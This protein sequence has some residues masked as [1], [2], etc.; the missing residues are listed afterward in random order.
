[1]A[2]QPG[3]LS[4]SIHQATAW[5]EAYSRFETPEQEIRKFTKRLKAMGFLFLKKDQAIV[6]L[7]CGRGNGLIALSRMGFSRIDGVDL[8]LFLLS[9]YSGTAVCHVAD[10]RTLPLANDSKDVVVVQGGLHHL[11]FIPDDLDQCLREIRRILSP[12]GQVFIVEPW[13][14]PFLSIVHA[15]CKSKWIRRLVPKIDALA[16]MIEQ[17]HVTY[18]QWLNQ[19]EKILAALDAYFVCKRIKCRW[20]KLIF[21]GSVR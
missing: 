1:M 8:S 7:F 13:L 14:T 12:Q 21:V 5:E 17:E 18:S 10:C 9:Q 16:T 3:N 4:P 2:T 20:G 19:P 11:Q 6:E 15:I